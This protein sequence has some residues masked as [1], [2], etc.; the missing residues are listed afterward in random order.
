MSAQATSVSALIATMILSDHRILELAWATPFSVPL[1]WTELRE[2]TYLAHQPWSARLPDHVFDSAWAR[3]QHGS[4]SQ[5]APL[6]AIQYLVDE[7]TELRHGSVR[8][9]REA[10]GPWQ[11]GICSRMSTMPVHAAATAQTFAGCGL[12]SSPT[13]GSRHSQRKHGTERWRNGQL[14][15]LRPEEPSVVDYIEREGLHETHLHLNGSTHAEIC[16][17]RALNYPRAE[18]RRFVSVWRNGAGA[19]RVRELVKQS[20]PELTPRR[21]FQHLRAASG[22]RSWLVAAANGSLGQEDPLPYSCQELCSQGD[23]LTPEGMKATAPQCNQQFDVASE[24]AWM[25][26]LIMRLAQEPSIQLTR[27]FHAYVLLSND[28]YKLLVQGES[29]FGFDQF[30]KFTLTELREPAEEDYA[31][32]FHA[33]HGAAQTSTIGYLEGRFAPKSDPSKSSRL[34]KS[35]LSGYLAYL[36]DP[37][38]KSG[39]QKIKRKSLSCILAELEEYFLNPSAH[40]RD[41][42]RLALVVHFIKQPWPPTNKLSSGPYR[43]YPLFMQLRRTTGVLISTLSRWPRL[44]TWIRGIDA[45][46]NELHAPPDVFAPIF[47]ACQRGGLTHQTYHAGEDFRHLLA[48]IATMRDALT[49]LDL[50]D[51]DRIGH[52]TAMGIR[53]S[54]WIERMPE[55]LSITRGE[56]ML[57]LLAS[58]QLSRNLPDMQSSTQRLQCELEIVA[59]QI[60]G[61]SVSALAI[62]RSMALRGLCRYELHRQCSG[63]ASAGDEPLSYLWRDESDMVRDAIAKHPDDVNLLWKWLSTPEIIKRADEWILADSGFLDAPSYVRIQQALMKMIS[64]RCV[65]VETLP[66]SNVRISQYYSADEHHALRWMGVPG[67]VEEGDPEVMVSLGSDDPGIFAGDLETEFYLLYTTLRKHGL[68]DAASLRRLAVLN[69]RGRVYRFHDRALS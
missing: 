23:E 15:L 62:E 64:D 48:G 11:Q 37:Q 9:R 34:I 18:I 65:V 52:G 42:H 59:N 69:E 47:R 41:V 53:P 6:A 50:R 21:L 28:Y 1:G 46:A 33:M 51:G 19:A 10:L 60:F 38:Q 56:W 67:H 32:R 31:A 30:Q 17:L 57:S 39:D 3:L 29:Q 61:S 26:K 16:W 20:S 12:Q 54:L 2:P 49:L 35:I 43:H 14:P 4:H 22:L 63:T 5:S 7:F 68:S 24:L 8:L 27:M 66:S 44:R 13:T 36:H 58:W 40:H 55:T 45:A 25:T